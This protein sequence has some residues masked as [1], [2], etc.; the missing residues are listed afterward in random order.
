MERSLQLQREITEQRRAEGKSDF[1]CKGT[2]EI[3]DAGGL[4]FSQLHVGGLRLLARVL[5]LGAAHYPENLGKAEPWHASRLPPS[6]APF[7]L[8]ETTTIA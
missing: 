1:I 5:G 8:D 6:V 7:D 4:A 2:L 3:Y